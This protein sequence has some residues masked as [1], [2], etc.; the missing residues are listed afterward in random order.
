MNLKG[1]RRLRDDNRGMSPTIGVILMIVVTVL[2]AAVVAA[3]AYSLIEGVKKAPNAALVIDTSRSGSDVNIEI[4]HVR[5]NSIGGA[6]NASAQSEL[7]D[8]WANLEVR[9][10]GATV[11][12]ATA[13]SL[14]M[15]G[16]EESG[17]WVVSSFGP[18]DQINIVFSSLKS[19]DS[20]TVV[21][22]LSESI[23]Q[24]ITY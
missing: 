8:K 9:L 11:S 24:R 16:I 21:H 20:I 3:T 12:N 14:S 4:Y 6:F 17:D 23:L 18:G 2:I 10:N 5:G 1:K 22:V 7:G 19:G 13:S 15:N